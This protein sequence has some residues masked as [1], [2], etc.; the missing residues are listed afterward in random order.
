M[1]VGV[2]GELHIGGAGVARGY[3]Q[4]PALTA[5]RFIAAPFA[6]AGGAR[7]YRTGDVGRWLPDGRIEYQG[8]NDFQVKLRGY[9]IELGEIEAALLGCAGVREA[10]VLARE[11][12]PGDKRL[13]AYLVAA[14]GGTLQIGELRSELGTVLAEYMVP[15]AY[16]VLEALPLTRNGKLDRRALPAPDQSALLMGQYEAPQ[17]GTEIELAA[18]W[19]D[20]LK[21]EQ[22]GRHDDFFALGGH[23]LLAALVISRISSNL[24]V[25]LPMVALFTHP[26]LKGLGEAIVELTLEK[27][28]QDD[29]ALAAADL[30]AMSEEEI[31][32][33][34][35]QERA[36]TSAAD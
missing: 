7:L 14:E 1:P 34:L 22:V 11:D 5:E 36:L 31:M 23:S 8:R 15:S 26:T 6:E 20:V 16:V 28:A 33:M 13:V 12:V 4:R 24:A 29:I 27:F 19:R 2:S 18:I 30:D 17:G 10:V 35:E 32:L 21:V 9:R 25:E 3:L